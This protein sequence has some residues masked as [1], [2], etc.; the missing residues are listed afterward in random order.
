MQVQKPQEDFVALPLLQVDQ[1]L[2]VDPLEN[3]LIALAQLPFKA[4]RVEQVHILG[5]VAIYKRD[6]AAVA[7]VRQP[8]PGFFEHLA[9]DAV[10]R[11]LAGLKLAADADPLVFVFIVLFFHAVEHQILPVPLQIAKR[12]VFHVCLPMVRCAFYCIRLRGE[13]QEKPVFGGML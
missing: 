9:A 11:A 4:G 12:G 6:D 5:P 7:V 10:L 8:E 1:P 3:A 2:F 13:L